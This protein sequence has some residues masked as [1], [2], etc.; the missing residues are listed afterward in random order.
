MLW[1][2]LTQTRNRQ[3]TRNRHAQCEPNAKVAQWYHFPPARFM[4][5]VG[6][7]VGIAPRYAQHK[8]LT[9]LLGS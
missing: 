9:E 1:I 3:T 4:A 2:Y 7:N 5:H 8:D 6:H